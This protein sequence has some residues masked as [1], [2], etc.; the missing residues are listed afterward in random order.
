[1]TPALLPPPPPLPPPSRNPFPSPHTPFYF[2]SFFPPFYSS[3]PFPSPSSS[4]SSSSAMTQSS[5][6][7]CNDTCC[8][9]EDGSDNTFCFSDR[10]FPQEL[11][12]TPAWE[13]GVR[14][15][16]ATFLCVSGVLGNLCILVILL[17]NRLLLRTSVNLFILNMSVADLV[18]AG[19]G[20]LPYTARDT[21]QFWTLGKAWCHLEG[22]L[23]MMVM[24]VSVLSLATISCDR[25]VGVVY[26]FHRHLRAWQSGIVIVVI[27]LVS[28]GIAVPFGLYREYTV[29]KWRDVTERTCE[30]AEEMQVWWLVSII[31]LTWLPLAVMLA[32]YT[33]IFINFNKYKN[34]VRGREHPAILRMK[35]RTVRM[36]FVVVMLFVA[37]WTPLQVVTLARNAFVEENGSLKK[38][39]AETYNTLMS[40]CQYMMYINPAVNPIVYALMHHNFKRAFRVTFT[41][42]FKRKP[43]FVLTPGHGTQKYVWSARSPVNRNGSHT[44]SP[45]QRL[46]RQGFRRAGAPG[47]PAPRPPDVPSLGSR[48][49]EGIGRSGSGESRGGG[50]SRLPEGAR[51]GDA[52]SR[53]PSPRGKNCDIFLGH[54]VTQ[55][56]EE[57]TSSDLDSERTM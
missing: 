43:S 35:A 46:R 53:K 51:G 23:Q 20:P 49:S 34:K 33:L 25:M 28:A 31:A 10:D 29:H 36:M 11:V 13:L 22:C 3:P 55:V 7:T 15:G 54:L 57:E 26:P 18:T 41:C 8:S 37:C 40:V 24:M 5:G 6:M 27:W 1:M 4:S 30:E 45:F 21:Q 9:W 56:I 12:A 52:S 19:A 50:E 42:V 2:L 16:A 32:C 14:Y 38:D 44:R 47:S 48:A 39:L 17:K